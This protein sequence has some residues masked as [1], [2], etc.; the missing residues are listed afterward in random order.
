ML[1]RKA[2]DVNIYQENVKS[3]VEY[4]LKESIYDF[5]LVAL[6]N[7]KE[8]N[9]WPTKGG[10]LEPILMERRARN[11]IFQGAVIVIFM[12][13]ITLYLLYRMFIE[14]DEDNVAV[15]DFKI[16]IPRLIA[17]FFMHSTLEP[18]VRKG[19]AIMK[20]V[21]NHPYLFSI[22]DF[23]DDFEDDEDD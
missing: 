17:S 20:F 2:R 4:K 3:T 16:L 14:R 6:I 13:L 19:I 9:D 7:P 10:Y 22:Y 18:Y 21:T 11:S 15:S 12:Q 8:M 5:A 1:N 23:N